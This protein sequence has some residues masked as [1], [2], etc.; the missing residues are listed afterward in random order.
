MGSGVRCCCAPGKAERSA[1]LIAD[2]H[3]LVADVVTS[4]AVLVGVALV[5]LTGMLVIDSMIAAIVALNVLWS[6]WKVITQNI[7]GLLDE[8]APAAELQ[9]IRDIIAQNGGSS[10]EAHAL[11][12]RHSGKMTFIE[13]HLV[14]DGATTVR[15]AHE[16]C[17]RIEHA[18]KKAMPGA[19][20]SIHVEP[21]HKARH[22]GII[23]SG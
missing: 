23:F 3:H 9:Q 15:D 8:A 17:D 19:T 16:T 4:V 18:L 11:R 21:E 13:F 10:L 5:V 14:V 2:G 1:A 6:G 20:V 22:E 12:T 7:S